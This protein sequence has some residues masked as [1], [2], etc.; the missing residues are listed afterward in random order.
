[1]NIAVLVNSCHEYHEKTLPVVLSSLARAGVDASRIF[2][3]VGDSP[4]ESKETVVVGEVDYNVWKVTEC[5][6]DTTALIWAVGKDGQE[7]L[8]PFEYVFYVHDT[9][10]VLPVFGE[11]LDATLDAWQNPDALMLGHLSM[12][13]GYYNLDALRRLETKI[14]ALANRDPERRSSIKPGSEDQVFRMMQ[15]EGMV[16]KNLGQYCDVD[17]TLQPYGGQKR[18]RETWALPGFVKYKANWGQGGCYM[19][20]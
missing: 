6:V 17:E 15:D 10:E 2:V 18:Q 13:T 16:V 19:G 14:L 9:V 5:N 7:A 11:N 3:V 20:A 4:R 1:M 8:L 12:S